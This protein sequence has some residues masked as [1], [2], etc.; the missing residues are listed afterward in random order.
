[1]KNRILSLL[2][3]AALALSVGLIGCGGEEVPEISEY[4]LAISS[5]EGGSVT[6]P[7]EG[8]F[9]YDEGEVMDLEAT[10]D[11][12]YHFVNWTGDVSTIADVEDASTTI[13]MD[14]A[15]SVT[16]NFA[17]LRCDLILDSTEG[18]SVTTPVEGTSSYDYG[19]V[20]DFAVQ[21]A[22]GYRFTRWTGD[23]DFVADVDSAS[24]NV[25]MN[26][27]YHITANFEELDPGTPFAGGSGKAG[28]PYQIAN[29]NHLDNVRDYLDGYFI[30]IK[31]L[32]STTAGYADLASPTA[33]Q[34]KGWQPIGSISVDPFY[35]YIVNPADS[36]T[37]TLDGQGYEIRDLFIGRPDEDGVGLF[38]CVGRGG[39][40]ENLG[41]VNAE[42]TGH[43]YVGGLV[44]E[45]HDGT[46]SN[47]HS[48]GSVTG[49]SQYVG[50]LMGANRRTVSNSYFTGSVTSGD[51][52]VGGLAGG[53][54]GTVNNSYSTDSVT[55]EGHVGGLI[56]GNWGTVSNSYSSSGVIGSSPVGGLVAFNHLGSVS[57]SYFTGSVTTHSYG[58]VGGL[59]GE[60]H[61]GTVSN[62]YYSYDEVLINA[63]HIIAIGALSNED[64]EQWLTNDKLLNVN[65]RLSQED[66]YYLINDVSD[67]KSLL[68]FG[69][70]GALKFRLKNDLDLGGEPN[71]YIPY[72]AGEFDG[73]GHKIANL[74]FSFDFIAQV[75]LFGYL[76][77]G[78]K[79]TGVGAENV[80]I[81]ANGIVGG[82]VAENDG[83]VSNSY[84][85][86]SVGG[87]WS[88]GGLVGWIGYNGGT[89]SNSYYSYDEVLI[90]GKKI[91]TIGALFDGDFD[92][93]LANDKFLDVNERLSQEDGYYLISDISDFKQ[94]LAFGQDSSLKFRL[95][96]DL[97]LAT[98]ANFYVPYLAGEFD[99][100]GH[101]I[102]NFK[103][104]SHSISQVGLFGYLAHSGKINEA[105]VE[106]VNVAGARQVGGL[107][108]GNSGTVI[109]SYS[110]GSVTGS[111]EV[112]GLVGWNAGTV[113]NS[114]SNGSMTGSVTNAVDIGGLV[115][116]NWGTVS[117]SYS[118][119]RVTGNWRVG[120]L[121]GGNWD[122]VINCYS[123][124][125][126]TGESEVGALVGGNCGT[127]SNSFWDIETGGQ[128]TSACGTGKNTTE[129]QEIATFAGA[130]WNI[131]A[132]ANPDTRNPSYIWNI[133]DGQTYPF[134]SWEHVS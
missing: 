118:T 66:G 122:T 108:G 93:W 83:M 15:K 45:N 68:A 39:V 62:S 124:G 115:G 58:P 96:N 129:M 72:L 69:Q 121:A 3:A 117:N 41:V 67:F 113:I 71:F 109:N 55:G 91:I 105:G 82:L 119:G 9:T 38:S 8:T 106:N 133:V 79:V 101:K 103:L 120:G 126:V 34:G 10:P 49:Y 88:V 24:T 33:N 65:E 99:G 7:G 86:G 114:Y 134:L 53:N 63:R 60:N 56:G 30:L 50:G 14:A 92:Q 100:N 51:L 2:L 11:E 125:S 28:D 4:N 40:I 87:Y 54:W 78:G 130:G 5:T 97:N 104:N 74:S 42:V 47:S 1:V 48:T 22:E 73:N 59:V 94:L 57:N 85:T 26:D 19:T 84:A 16:A 18:G 131:V 37:G 98:Q 36:F 107:A 25:I 123:T 61:D 89:V 76:A 13:I 77:S 27:H 112:G 46:V 110:T 116:G 43:V 12:G 21:S 102:S 32:R 52:W 128:P 127:V 23:L 6:T 31:D 111:H 80:N 29:W 44:G 132:V 35:F 95:K 75:G 64:F 81:F 90:N 20:V 70:N 17:P